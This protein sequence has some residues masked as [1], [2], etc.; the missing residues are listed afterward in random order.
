M[1]RLKTWILTLGM[2]FTETFILCVIWNLVEPNPVYIR[3]LEIVLPGF[4]WLT[5]RHLLLGLVESFLYGTYIAVAFVPLH[6][7]LYRRHEREA[8]SRTSG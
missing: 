8:K 2:L 3:T 7:F 5:F 1:F 6:N 4:K